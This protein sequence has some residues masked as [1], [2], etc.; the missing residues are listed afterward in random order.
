MLLPWL[1][2]LSLVARAEVVDRV[3]AVV[4]EH[5]VLDSEVHLEAT[6]SRLDVHALP[7]W[8][9]THDDPLQRLIDAAVIRN[10]AGELALYAPQEEAVRDRLELLRARFPDRASWEAFLGSWGLD[11]DALLS[12]LRRRM[13]VERF[14]L[15][16]VQVPVDDRRAW[17]VAADAVVDQLQTRYR[18]RLV[19]QRGAGAARGG[20]QGPPEDAP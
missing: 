6:L 3:V 5:L 10:A 9:A 7:F 19:P 18:I 2:S 17:L 4:G 16:S 1:L 12:V 11:E 13:M 8:E 15:R 20:Q 14:L